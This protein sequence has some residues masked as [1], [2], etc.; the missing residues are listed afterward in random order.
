MT[1]APA[2]PVEWRPRTTRLVA[3]A[4]AGAIIVAMIVLAVF[5][6]PQF[7][8]VDRVLMV[9][10]GLGLAWILHM[11]GRCRVGADES[12]LT[13]VN[14]FR[15]RRLEWPE[16]VDVTMTVGDPWPRLDLSDGTALGVMGIQGAEK[17]LAA[18]QVTELAALLKTRAEAPDPT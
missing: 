10:F 5:V 2:L 8:I 11:L 4:T 17:K 6:A 3:Y 7:T 14:A 12:G 16:V 18:R 9:V 13:I 1:E 15:T